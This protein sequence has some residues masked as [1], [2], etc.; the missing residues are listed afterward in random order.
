M[1]GIQNI[2]PYGVNSNLQASRS[3]L[4]DAYKKNE[5]VH[6]TG[7]GIFSLSAKIVDK[8]EPSEALRATTVWSKGLAN[9]NYL[10]SSDQLDGFR[11]GEELTEEDLMAALSYAAEREH[12][13]RIAS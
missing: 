12:K 8:A 13:I 11:R 2:L 7:M 9:A 10:L 1:D 5:L 4:V 6:E 3:T